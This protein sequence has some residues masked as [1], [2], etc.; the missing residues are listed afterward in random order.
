[1]IPLLILAGLAIA[2][3]AVAITFWDQI[4]KYLALAFD[5]VKKIINASII[6]AMA[7]VQTG[8]WRKG[9]KAAYKF[10]SK[11]AE[12]QWQE[13]VTTKTITADEVPAHIRKKLEATTQPID[14]SDE[15]ELELT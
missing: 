11:N 8:N 13:T 4:K 7:Y 2:G 3:T 14:I 12:G 5:K 1:M 9:I 6:G 10:Y 15:L